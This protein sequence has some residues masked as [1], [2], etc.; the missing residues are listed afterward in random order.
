MV[1]ISSKGTTRILHTMF[2][3]TEQKI[4]REFVKFSFRTI[5]L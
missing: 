3:N 5:T 1:T 2:T 4:A